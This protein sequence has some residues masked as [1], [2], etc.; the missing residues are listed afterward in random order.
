MQTKPEVNLDLVHECVHAL[1]DCAEIY[2]H[3][4]TEAVITSAN[5]GTHGGGSLH[6]FGRAFDLRLPSRCL[7]GEIAWDGTSS[8]FDHIVAGEIRERL[9]DRGFDVVL[10]LHQ[11]NPSLWHIHVEHDPS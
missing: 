5:D 7:A 1:A 11:T 4:G 6:P 9:R 2:R 3:F 8:L 10:E